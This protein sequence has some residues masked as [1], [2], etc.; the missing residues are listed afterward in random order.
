MRAL[1]SAQ[2]HALSAISA[3]VHL[4]LI[5]ASSESDC[6][7]GRGRNNSPPPDRRTMMTTT[8]RPAPAA[9]ETRHGSLLALHVLVSLGL[10][11]LLFAVFRALVL[12]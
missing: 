10:W 6:L 9:A 4:V 2:T 8:Q 5:G 7:I 11:F 12:Q 3:A 1:N